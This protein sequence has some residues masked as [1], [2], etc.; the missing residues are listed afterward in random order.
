MRPRGAQPV[1]S[2][3]LLLSL[4]GYTGASLSWHKA[5]DLH[6][7]TPCTVSHASTR[8]VSSLPE[9]VNKAQ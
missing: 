9:G 1:N 2:P 6:S 8:S 5:R 3:S 7:S 4:T